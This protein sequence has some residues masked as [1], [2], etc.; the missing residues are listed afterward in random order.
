MTVVAK[1]TTASIEDYGYNR[2]VKLT[3][4]YD[5]AINRGDDPENRSF[6]RATPWG[7]CAMTIDNP[8]AVEQ[9]RIAKPLEGGGHQMASTHYVLFIDASKNS[10]EDVMLAA[11]KL[12]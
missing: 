10:L 2:K 3:C 4:Q 12:A 6:T 1:M 5:G 9:F 11:S 7:E 8:Y